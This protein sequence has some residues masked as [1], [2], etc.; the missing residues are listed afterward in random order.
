MVIN[1]NKGPTGVVNMGLVAHCFV[2]TGLVA[3]FF[4]IEMIVISAL[5]HKVFEELFQ[6][7]LN[8]QNI[9]FASLY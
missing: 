3:H 8:C 9:V 1:V 2:N 6:G 7:V 5:M 4:K